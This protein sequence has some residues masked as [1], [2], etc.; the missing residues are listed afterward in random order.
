MDAAWL[1]GLLGGLLIGLASA[2]LLLGNGRIAGASGILRGFLKLDLD[3]VWLERAGFVA[4]LVAVPVV[5]AEM[6]G[7]PELEA[8][9]GVAVMAAGGVLVGIGVRWANGCTS[10]HGVCGLSRLSRRSIAA[11]A[12]FMAATAL[13]VFVVRHVMGL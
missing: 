2:I 12:T 7:R 6:V 4:A 1:D 3:E 8:P 11:T 5:Y 10:G 9:F 13:T